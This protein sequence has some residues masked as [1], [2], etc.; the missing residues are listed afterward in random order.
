MTFAL[1]H[2]IKVSL[3]DRVG[4]FNDLSNDETTQIMLATL[5]VDSIHAEYEACRAEGKPIR[6][7][8][9]F[10]VV[11]KTVDGAA[12]CQIAAKR[13][14]YCGNFTFTPGALYLLAELSKGNPGKVVQLTYLAFRAFV[15]NSD[16]RVVSSQDFLQLFGTGFPP[17]HVYDEC[18]DAQKII[19]Q[20]MIDIFFTWLCETPQRTIA[21]GYA[22]ADFEA[23]AKTQCKLI[24]WVFEEACKA[25]GEDAVIERVYTHL[26]AR[27]LP[28]AN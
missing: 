4:M 27:T 24:G 5:S 6:H 28:E 13:A 21:E 7:D 12:I 11:V 18:W 9:L 25:H 20:N 23:F 14:A 1:P 19:G 17:S 16:K 15:C 26:P 2:P 3:I 22:N 10:D 8:E